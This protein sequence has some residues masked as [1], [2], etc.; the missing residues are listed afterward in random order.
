DV[1]AVDARH[2]RVP[3]PRPA[4]GRPP[5]QRGVDV[6]TQLTTEVP[7]HRKP[8][9]RFQVVGVLVFVLGATSGSYLAL[10]RDD[11]PAPPAE[12][13]ADASVDPAL[14]AGPGSAKVKAEQAAEAAAER[15]RQAA[16]AVAAEEAAR[17]EAAQTPMP[18]V[19]GSCDEYS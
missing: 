14:L 13:S 6:P 18:D 8:A 11:A 9:R 15:A 2:G 1:T 4:P 12:L 5:H 3:E 17:Q 16:E 19:P 10:A 7:R